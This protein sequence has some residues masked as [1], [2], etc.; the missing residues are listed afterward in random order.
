MNIKCEE[1]ENCP[2]L[3]A[4]G[5]QIIDECY[6]Y[7]DGAKKISKGYVSSL[8]EDHPCYQSNSLSPGCTYCRDKDLCNAD[9]SCF[10]CNSSTTPGC[11][12]GKD[13]DTVPCD[14]DDKGNLCVSYINGKHDSSI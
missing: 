2:K 13:L 3:K 7:N 11:L 12:T 6:R 5:D 8:K 14:K 4:G 10:R 1:C 9:N